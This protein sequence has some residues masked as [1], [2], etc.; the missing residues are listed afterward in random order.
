MERANRLPPRTDLN[1]EACGPVACNRNGGVEDAEQ[2][3]HVV[4]IA[5]K[6]CMSAQLRRRSA[7]AAGCWHAIPNPAAAARVLMM[8]A[9][10]DASQSGI[11]RGV[12]DPT[13]CAQV[14]CTRKS[15]VP[16]DMHSV[17]SHAF[18]RSRPG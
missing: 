17:G 13:M 7:S 4:Q 3:R 2:G 5:L 9:R 6:A 15:G 14:T 12:V 18:W 11:P 8:T 1:R 16:P 10:Y